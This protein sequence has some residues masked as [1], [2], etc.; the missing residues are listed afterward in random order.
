MDVQLS[1]LLTVQKSLGRD[2]GTKQAPSTF[3]D[4]VYL[5]PQQAPFWTD[6]Q[7]GL[8]IPMMVQK[9]VGKQTDVPTNLITDMVGWVM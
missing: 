1:S 3:I 9:F 5:A 2:T 6:K 8:K 4:P 7:S